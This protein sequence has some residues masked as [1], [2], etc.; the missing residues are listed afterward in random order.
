MKEVNISVFDLFRIEHVPPSGGIKSNSFLSVPP[1][2]WAKC[3]SICTCKH[4]YDPVAQFLNRT[5]KGKSLF[6]QVVYVFLIIS[7]KNRSIVSIIIVF[8]SY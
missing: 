3:S 7:H 1:F 4:Y 2:S 8:I 6:S 5:I